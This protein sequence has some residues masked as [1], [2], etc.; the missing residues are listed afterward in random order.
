MAAHTSRVAKPA[1]P[2]VMVIFGAGGDRDREKRPL[3][4]RAVESGAD[5]A[6]MS[7]SG[8]SVVGIYADAETARAAHRR[9]RAAH[10]RA[11]LLVPLQSGG[12]TD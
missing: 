5:L 6:V 9:A 11:W 10:P 12:F 2:G 8:S 4:G 7:G 3:M 1:P